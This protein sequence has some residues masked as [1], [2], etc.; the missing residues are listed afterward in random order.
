MVSYQTA[1]RSRPQLSMLAAL[2]E[3]GGGTQAN[4]DHDAGEEGDA[5]VKPGSNAM[6]SGRRRAQDASIIVRR[7]AVAH[8]RHERLLGRHRRAVRRG[9]FQRVGGSAKLGCARAQVRSSSMR[10]ALSRT[11]AY[12]YEAGGGS[13]A[14]AEPASAAFPWHPLSFDESSFSIRAPPVA[15]STRPF[16]LSFPRRAATRGQTP[17]HLGGRP[18]AEALGAD[19]QMVTAL[20]AEPN[21]ASYR[22]SYHDTANPAAPIPWP[23]RIIIR[24]ARPAVPP[25]RSPPTGRGPLIGPTFRPPP[26]RRRCRRRRR[27]RRRR[28][29]RRRCRRHPRRRR[30]LRRPR[31]RR[32]SPPAAVAARAAASAARRPPSL[33]PCAA[34]AVAAAIAAAVD[35]AADDTAAALPPPSLPPSPP[36]PFP[37]PPHVRA[38]PA[39]S[40]SLP[41][42]ATATLPARRRADLSEPVRPAPSTGRAPSRSRVATAPPSAQRISFS[43]A[44]L[45]V[46]VR[47]TRRPSPPMPPLAT[48][49]SPCCA[50]WLLVA[51]A[52]RR[53]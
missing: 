27:H 36:P 51:A 4:C 28:R 37:P 7:G 14:A 26:R 30:R 40:L 17:A 23:T 29:R 5:A 10:S 11:F 39:A 31:R 6:S 52:R 42:V 43:S 49:R 25:R 41:F 44:T 13:A 8:R 21:G 15:A 22:W 47:A 45:L 50:P 34:A 38:S 20:G 48:R 2:S 35:A 3:G 24:H 18:L 1:A 33:P 32:P 16:R 9:L 46:C 19:G 53:S 12:E